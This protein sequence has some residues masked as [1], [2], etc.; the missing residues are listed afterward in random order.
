VKVAFLFLRNMKRKLVLVLTGVI[1]AAMTISPLAVL[2][3]APTITTDAATPISGTSETLN[4]TITDLG[5]NTGYVYLSFQYA[6]DDYYITHGSTY[7]QYTP[8]VAWDTTDGIT[9]FQADISSLASDT[10]YH[11]MA[12]IRYGILKAYGADANFTTSMSEPASAPLVWQIK[13]FRNL[14]A[15]GD[16]LYCVYANIPYTVIPDTLESDGYYWSIVDDTG[17]ILGNT[18]GYSYYQNGYN[19]NL[20]ALYFDATAG[21]TWGTEYT[22][23][24]SGNPA[25]FAVPP[26]YNWT[27]S[28]T[29]YTTYTTQ[30]DNQ[31]SLAEYGIIWAR[32]L[33]N[34]WQVNLIDEQDT[35]S[36]LSANGE[37][38]FRNAIFGIQYMAPS[39]FYAQSTAV[40]LSLRGGG[41]ALGDTYKLRLGGTYIETALQEV[42]DTINIPLILLYGVL[43]IGI[44]VFFVWQSNKRFQTAMPGYIA[45]LL[46]VMCAGMLALGFTLI[47]LIALALVLMAGWFLFLKKA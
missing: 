11:F 1:I 37:K 5:G 43:T 7:N 32:N 31:K 9:T 8:E 25:A 39:L 28:S 17:T 12:I 30:A 10:K 47:A 34:K 3:V 42:A 44:C 45:S 23:R 27:V 20:Y 19:Y 36:V 6:T 13:I 26:V 41:T 15:S 38:F 14:L 22:L 16:S 18:N 21:L 35:G 40:D 2:A 4:G 33:E 46:V 24:L 29:D